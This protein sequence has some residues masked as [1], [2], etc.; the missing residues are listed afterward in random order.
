MREGNEN[1]D[2]E[3]WGGGTSEESDGGAWA[4]AL[5][6]DPGEWQGALRRVVQLTASGTTERDL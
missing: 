6:D 3:D 1:D 5:T 2:E 4:E